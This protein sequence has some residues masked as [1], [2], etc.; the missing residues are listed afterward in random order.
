MNKEWF[1]KNNE[2]MQLQHQLFQ[3]ACKY[4]TLPGQN[5]LPQLFVVV[6]IP[7]H[8]IIQYHK[9]TQAINNTNKCLLDITYV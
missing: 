6:F 8:T 9:K 3:I 7:I 4:I 5:F 2:R 1:G